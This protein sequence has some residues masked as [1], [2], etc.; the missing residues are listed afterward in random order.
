MHTLQLD[1]GDAGCTDLILLIAGEMKRLD[2]GQTIE[3]FST[4]LAA[5]VDIPAWCRMTGHALLVMNAETQPKRFV[6]Q[7]RQ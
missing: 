6:I 4:D 2:G 1:A 7:K 5:H 3:L